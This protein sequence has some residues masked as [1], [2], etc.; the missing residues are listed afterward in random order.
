M[1]TSVFFRQSI[2]YTMG[3]IQFALYREMFRY[4]NLNHLHATRREGCCFNAAV[5]LLGLYCT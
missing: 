2:I 5:P 4:D 1:L 3:P